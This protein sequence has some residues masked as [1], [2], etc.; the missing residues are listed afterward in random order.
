MY[1]AVRE[2]EVRPTEFEEEFQPG[3]VELGPDLRQQGTLRTSGRAELIREH[4]GPRQILQDIRLVGEFGTSVEVSCARCL[5]P[6]R[7]DISRSFDLL[8]RPRG[9]DAGKSEMAIHEAD[10]EI[11]YYEGEGILLEDVLR[12]QVLLAAP[13]RLVCGEE[14]RGL[15][16]HCGQ[17][18]NRG[19]CSCAERF[20]DPRWDVLQD[21]RDRLD[22]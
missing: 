21:I 11:G 10:T 1:I 5:E 16:P 6:V 20:R 15:C 4:R 17:N 19:A 3:S 18:L 22:K 13:I 7:R 8:Y 12:E 2:L 9:A 14:C